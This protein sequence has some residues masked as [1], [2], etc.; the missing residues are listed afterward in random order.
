[1]WVTF[2]YA[3]HLS[4]LHHAQGKATDNRPLDEYL[5]RGR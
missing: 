1:M 5:A 2:S 3:H 4:T